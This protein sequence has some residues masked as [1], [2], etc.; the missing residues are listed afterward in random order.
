MKKLLLSLIVMVGLVGMVRA[1]MDGDLNLFSSTTGIVGMNA[2]GVKLQFNPGLT[3]EIIEFGVSLSS[4]MTKDDA[5]TMTADKV[6]TVGGSSY[7]G[8][9]GTMT[10]G[11][12]IATQTTPGSVIASRPI[13]K[14]ILRPGEGMNLNVTDACAFTAGVPYILYRYVPYRDRSSVYAV[15]Q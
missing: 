14:K 5:F 8:F 1:S 15:T 7:A 12:S 10:I 2:T 9:I 6:P 13:E 4:G 3:V 11:V